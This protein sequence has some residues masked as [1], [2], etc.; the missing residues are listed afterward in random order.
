MAVELQIAE[1]QRES[2]LAQLGPATTLA[3]AKGTAT[4]SMQLPRQAVALITLRY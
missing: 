2:E 1:L 3:T 4:V